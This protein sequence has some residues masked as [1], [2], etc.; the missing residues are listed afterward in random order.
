M[1]VKLRFKQNTTFKN[2]LEKH[3]HTTKLHDKNTKIYTFYC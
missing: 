3:K 2:R 1:T